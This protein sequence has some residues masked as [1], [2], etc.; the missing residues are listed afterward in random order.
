M[1]NGNLEVHDNRFLGQ[2]QKN[3][4]NITRSKGLWY[5]SCQEENG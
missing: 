2:N 1:E 5:M 4:E 3:K